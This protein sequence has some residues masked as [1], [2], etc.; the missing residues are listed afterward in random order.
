MNK[1]NKLICAV[2]GLDPFPKEFLKDIH[3]I[4]VRDMEDLS[5]TLAGK[6]HVFVLKCFNDFLKNEKIISIIKCNSPS[7]RIILY[8]AR[9]SDLKTSLLSRIDEVVEKSVS[10]NGLAITVEKVFF[11]ASYQEEFSDE[12]DLSAKNS[13]F[14]SAVL[15]VGALVI[16]L[17][18]YFVVKLF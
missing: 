10:M 15:G 8:G 12:I 3:V 13:W 7:T 17:L 9:K 1:E 11:S 14:L 6:P 16:I 4:H 2:L 5:V 18:C